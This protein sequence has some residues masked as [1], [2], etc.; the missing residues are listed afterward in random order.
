MS[1]PVTTGDDIAFQKKYLATLS[2]ENGDYIAMGDDIEEKQ[3]Y[4]NSAVSAWNIACLD[5]E[6]R[7][8]SI[9]KYMTEY[10]KLN[11]SSTKQT[12]FL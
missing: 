7:K 9:K 4:L 5:E 11:K 2:V 12:G 6:A 10:R 8:R 3:Q 1:R